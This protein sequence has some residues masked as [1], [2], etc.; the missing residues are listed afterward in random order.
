M[1]Y[2]QHTILL[3]DD[4]A[5]ILKALKRLLRQLKCNV[6]TSESPIASLEILE[7]ES[8]D[9]VISDMR[10]PEM[11]G[12]VFLEQVAERWPDVERVVMTGYADLQASIDAIN[13]GKISRFMAKPWKEDEVLEVVCKGFE[14][15][16]LR[17]RTDEL[18]KLT[19]QKNKELAVLN[20]S[21]ETKV[22][23][24]TLQ[25]RQANQGL[26][27]S[28]RS[29]VR[30]FSTLT[31]RRMGIKATADNQRLNKIMLG[32]AKKFG[33]EGAALKQLYYAWQ[34][35]NIGK[36]SLSDGL[37]FTPYTDLPAEQQREFQNHP[38]LAQA[39]TMLVKPL[40]PAGNIICQ[41][42]EYLDGTGYPRGLK[43]DDIK[44][45]A[46]ILCVVNDYIELVNGAYQER[47]FSTSEAMQ[48]LQGFAAEKYDDDVVQ[49]LAQV[50]EA[51]GS[52]GD[53]LQ[54]DCVASSDLKEGA[55][56]SRDL[57]SQQGILLLSEGQVL[58]ATIIEW[59]R[60]M[61]FNLEESFKIYVKNH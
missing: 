27:S 5:S 39:A 16:A 61:E 18:Q 28:Y 4:E 7:A 58:D 59:V 33:F 26:Q 29:V 56:L 17:R 3:V 20:Q 22:Q 35:R 31:A 52:H 32:V 9:L 50:L 24:R 47:Q 15:S 30:M 19:E 45:P 36:L 40:Y 14:L 41:H 11:G 53:T 38:L 49:A 44:L 55:Q 46:R 43:G 60:E 48:Y 6:L 13:R 25:L 12:E 10:M 37:V 23:E 42:K 57:I 21:L 2:A 8:V 1:D 54:D 51:L 34:L